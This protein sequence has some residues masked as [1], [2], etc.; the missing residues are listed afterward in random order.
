MR[1]LRALRR[2]VILLP[3]L[4]VLSLISALPQPAAAAAVP[5]AQLNTLWNTYGDQG[6]H[7][8]GADS[9]VS[10]PLPDGRVAWLFSDTF[11]GTVAA[12]H[13]R[14]KN[15]PFIHNSIVVQQGGQLVQTVTG[16]T[17]SAPASLVNAA[18]A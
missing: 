5:A 2:R 18:N 12:D 3:L 6:G 16:G 15:S 17:P 11:L 13:S 10:V 7:W 8:T 1:R 4:L 9:T 14:P